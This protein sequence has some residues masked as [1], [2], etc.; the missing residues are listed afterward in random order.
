[1]EACL[2]VVFKWTLF[3]SR[4]RMWNNH[5]GIILGSNNCIRT[6]AFFH[7]LI[8]INLFTLKQ[9]A[10]CFFPLKFCVTLSLNGLKDFHRD[11]STTLRRH[12]EGSDTL[13]NTF[14]PND[15]TTA[16]DPGLK[17]RT[18][19][20]VFHHVSQLDLLRRNKKQLKRRDGVKRTPRTSCFSASGEKEP[21]E[22]TAALSSS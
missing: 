4:L 1:M 7:F 11:L 17:D 8:L 2:T 15:A 5:K 21:S 20:A 18:R 6:S 10:L 3:P 13:S 9:I 14:F 16:C 19:K 12:A 22:H